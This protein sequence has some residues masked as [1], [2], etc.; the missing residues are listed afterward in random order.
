MSRQPPQVGGRLGGPRSG[1]RGRGEVG[2]VFQLFNFS[3]VWEGGPQ[4]G[5]RV[6]GPVSP[7]SPH[8]QQ[9]LTLPQPCARAACP[10]AFSPEL[11]EAQRRPRLIMESRGPRATWRGLLL[12]PLPP[13]SHEEQALRR[14]LLI[15]CWAERGSALRSSFCP[16][17]A[18]EQCLAPSLAPSICLWL[19]LIST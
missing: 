2:V 6:R 1:S 19:V 16:P 11:S 15:R 13:P 10:H 9:P 7:T 18:L 8:R 14:D 17:P 5:R 3:A 4:R 12:P